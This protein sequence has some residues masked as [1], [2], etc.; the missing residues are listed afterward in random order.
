MN[1][2]DELFGGDFS[3]VF[4]SRYFERLP[5]RGKASADA[6]KILDYERFVAIVSSQRLGHPQ[7]AVVRGGKSQ[8]TPTHRDGSTDL[9]RL[10]AEHQAGRT[11]VINQLERL[12]PSVACY[13]NRISAITGHCVHANAYM[14]PANAKGFSTHFDTHDVV[15]LQ[16]H[17]EKEWSVFQP[18]REVPKY[19]LAK[20]QD[21]PV[22][23]LEQTHLADLCL[24]RG[25]TL[26]L[27]RGYPHRARSRESTSIHVT[28][29]LR[30][31]TA[32]EV[33]LDAL[34][35]W[36]E[37]DPAAREHLS[38]GLAGALRKSQ[39]GDALVSTLRALLE[40]LDCQASLEAIR[41]DLVSRAGT[42]VVDSGAEIPKR[43]EECESLRYYASTH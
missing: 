14:T 16:T 43:D 33:I 26:Y 6:T 20:W 17:G 8:P 10:W 27:P 39:V 12:D 22:E 23:I 3:S 37:S 13:A 30:A 40:Q 41:S 9:S 4:E 42:A 25:D 28:F 34:T 7:V 35:K 11:V 5:K 32:H 36:H 18:P 15:V 1:V 2:L 29:G 19:P 24:Q 21:Q 31:V 38:L